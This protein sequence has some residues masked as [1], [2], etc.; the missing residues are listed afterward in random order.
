MSNEKEHIVEVQPPQPL[1]PRRKNVVELWRNGQLCDAEVV[2]SDGRTF[3][4]HRLVLAT[5]SDYMRALLAEDRFKDSTDCH[6][7][8]PD[9]S[10]RVLETVLEW[11]Y[12][13]TCGDGVQTMDGA[14]DVLE[15]ACRLQCQGLIKQLV[16]GL[17]DLID[18]ETCLSMWDL[19]ERLHLEELTSKATKVAASNFASLASGD[20]FEKLPFARLCKILDDEDLIDGANHA[21]LY[22]AIMRWA[23]AQD[24]FPSGEDLEQLLDH[25]HFAR[26]DKGFVEEHVL[27]NPLL[28][29]NPICFR[30]VAQSLLS[31]LDIL[32][33]SFKLNQDRV[34]R[35]RDHLEALKTQLLQSL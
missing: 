9:V 30:P 20:E 29:D 3:K 12:V 14:A 26:M 33:T 2:S 35:V 23:K 34:D 5:N 13:G 6:I 1:S 27:R 28:L 24:V 32:E 31:G 10:S 22:M 21:E 11:M 17:L 19:G 8:L 4:A 16:T 15:V 18:T 25:F 7:P